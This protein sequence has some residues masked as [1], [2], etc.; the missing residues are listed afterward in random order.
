MTVSQAYDAFCHL[1]EQR[2]LGTLKRSQFKATMTDLIREQ[3]GVGLRRD[4]PDSL[5]RHQEAWK[6][7]RLLNAETLAA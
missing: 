3:F 1:A 4:V 5:G 6:G 7:V 2:Q